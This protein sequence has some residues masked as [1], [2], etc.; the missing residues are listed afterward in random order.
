[1]FQLDLHNDRGPQTRH[2]DPVAAQSGVFGVIERGELSA[3]EA[4]RLGRDVQP[5]LAVETLTLP[6][7]WTAK[8]ITQRL[9]AMYRRLCR[10][11]PRK[12]QEKT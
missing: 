10:P 2:P 5:A 7:P 9:I 1:M 4:A 3:A 8:L 11:K 6:R 12:P